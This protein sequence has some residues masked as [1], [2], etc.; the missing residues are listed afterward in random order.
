[1][2]NRDIRKKLII[3]ADDFGWSA[4]A[5]RNILKLAEN[6]K[7]D[8]VAVL[9]NHGFFSAED[10]DRLVKSKVKL[11]IHLELPDGIKRK[12]K[13]KDM[14]LKRGLIFLLK[15]I[16][17]TNGKNIIKKE[18]EEQINKFKKIFGR[19]PDGA[20]SHEYIHFF[21]SYFGILIDLV[22]EK[23]IGFIRFGKK[24][25]IKKKSFVYYI[26][27]YL[28]NINK[29]KIY[30]SSIST[31]DYFVS[32]DWIRNLDKFFN[33]LPIGKTELITHPERESE[34]KIIDK[35]F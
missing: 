18:W 1:M 33:N 6:G 15:Y 32:L 17:G 24:G 29:R 12:K 31:S 10:I 9:I 3:S 8:R 7:L 5:N 21:P 2:L 35:N 20:N 4:L 13:L 30:N 28:H 26:L 11:D 22:K 14:V 27:L 34:L 23:K 25:P 16:S 19:F